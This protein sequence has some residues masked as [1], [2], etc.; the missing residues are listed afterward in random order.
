MKK[1]NSRRVK[2]VLNKI[3][4]SLKYLTLLIIS[5]LFILEFVIFP[6]LSAQI[7]Y[8]SFTYQ[9]DFENLFDSMSK[10]YKKTNEFQEYPFTTIK[11]IRHN[12]D[13]YIDKKVSITGHLE[14]PFMSMT[15]IPCLVDN[16]YIIYLDK[17]LNLKPK[18]NVKGMHVHPEPGIPLVTSGDTITI[19]GKIIYDETESVL[20]E[21]HEILYDGL[22]WSIKQP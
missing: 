13:G 14:I 20:I 21:P 10:Q 12:P 15:M 1:I 3:P 17:R 5:I 16:D 4:K 6:P 11:E 22:T 8:G 19:K 9:N 18:L 2:R 7:E